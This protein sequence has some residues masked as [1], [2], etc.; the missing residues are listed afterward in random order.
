MK[1]QSSLIIP[2]IFIAFILLNPFFCR[3]ID[4]GVYFITS[5]FDGHSVIV[6]PAGDIL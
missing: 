6:N 3:A 1:N 2:K 4:N 5:I